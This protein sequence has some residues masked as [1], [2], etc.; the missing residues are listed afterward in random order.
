MQELSSLW[1]RDGVIYQI[2][3]RSFADSNHDGIG[4]L[5]GII[6]HLDDLAALGIDA[7]WLSPINPS[8]DVTNYNEIDPKYGTLEDFDCLLQ[9]AHSRGIRV[10]LDLVLN[11]TSELHPWFQAARSSRDNPYH[12][13]YIW[14]SSGAHNRPPNNW[15]SVF[16]GGAWQ[17]ESSLD[18]YYYHMFYKEQPDLNW[19]HPPVR[20]AML[21][22][23]RFWLE[24][25]VD[26]FRLDVFNVFFKSA[27]LQDN[28]PK[29]G[30]RAF[31]R[32]QHIYDIDQDEMLPLLKEIR[33][34]LDSYPQRYAVGE[35]FLS[36]PT[37]AA[38]YCVGDLLPATFNFQFLFCPWRP[39]KFLSAIQRWEHSLTP[40]GWPT[41]VLNNH[42][43]PRSAT[44]YG[45]GEDDERLKV[46][47]AL[48]L[49]QRGTPYIYYGEEIGMRDITLRR[50]Q[51]M[52]PIARRYWPFFKG[53]DGCRSPMQWSAAPNAGFSETQPW[54][55]VHPNYLKRNLAAQRQDPD[56]LYHFY[57]RLI[58]LRREIPA[59]R[60]GMFLPLTYEPRAILAYLRQTPEQTV[61]VALNFGRRPL[62]LF[63]G[64]QLA[65]APWRL[66]LSNAREHF[67]GMD[68]D[69]L[70]MEPEEA[71]I[72]I[73]D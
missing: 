40:E 54:L 52:D 23:F 34:L 51:A 21:D 15:Q 9:E 68:Q 69:Y 39:G 7:I 35:T 70:C 47:A 62:R 37:K 43:N 19:H 33:S 53:R 63:L 49:T 42:D 71:C 28:P 58:Q 57:A 61:L 46:A 11:H 13:W 36:N 45:R 44:R 1:W 29:L 25:G 65:A 18:Q 4:D 27:H 55:P 17:Y 38:R 64:S 14:R 66:L 22:V 48:L 41:Y 73:Q 3:P 67:E 10:I 24:R 26:G 32:Q 31:D 6:A 12:D 60:L 30:L 56:S 72:L 5:G 16:G 8:P 20:Q 50:E 59:L 2:Y